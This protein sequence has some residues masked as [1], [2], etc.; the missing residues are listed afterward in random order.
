MSNFV[1]I[2]NQQ[3]F[4]PGVACASGLLSGGAGTQP[5][6]PSI[7]SGSERANAAFAYWP[8]IRLNTPEEVMRG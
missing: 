7:E 5:F 4:G 8:E 1:A 2:N 6:N 3:S